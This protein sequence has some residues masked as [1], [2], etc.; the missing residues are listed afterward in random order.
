MTRKKKVP[1]KIVNL[2]PEILKTGIKM[3]IGDAGKLRGNSWTYFQM[4]GR[5]QLRIC[6]AL[7]LWMLPSSLEYRQKKVQYWN[8]HILLITF[9]SSLSLSGVL[10]QNWTFLDKEV[11]G[12]RHGK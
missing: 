2:P 6:P 12:D 1:E 9:H 10:V 8:R 11:R 4:L 3:G 7:G 5:L